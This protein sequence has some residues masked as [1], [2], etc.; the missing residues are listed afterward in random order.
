MERSIFSHGYH[1]EHDDEINASRNKKPAARLST[2]F[3]NHQARPKLTNER[4]SKPKN[5]SIME[6]ISEEVISITFCAKSYRQQF[7]VSL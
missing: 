1:E 5:A 6:L 2:T 3:P 7:V 4:K